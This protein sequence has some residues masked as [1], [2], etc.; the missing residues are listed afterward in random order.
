MDGTAL[1][2]YFQR[3]LSLVLSGAVLHQQGGP[4]GNGPKMVV[5]GEYEI[6]LLI[7]ALER[8]FLFERKC[9]IIH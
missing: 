4:V 1:L 3:T 7:D 2:S 9:A 8:V 5:N 6:A